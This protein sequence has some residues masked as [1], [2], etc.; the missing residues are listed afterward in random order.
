MLTD[1]NGDFWIT[2]WDGLNRFD[3]V[4]NRFA[5]YK[6]G[7]AIG[8][9]RLWNVTED[10]KGIL[11]MG[12]TAGLNR[13][14]PATGQFTIYG[15]NLADPQSLSDNTATSVLVDHSGRM[16]ITT[17]NGFNE[18]DSSTGKFVTYYK[19]DGLPSSALSCVLEDQVGNLWIGTSN[20]LSKFDPLTRHFQNYST[21]DGIPGGD[22]MGWGTCFKKRDGEMFFAGFSGGVAFYPDRLDSRVNRTPIVLTDFQ[23]SGNSVEVGPRSPLKQSIGYTKNITLTPDEDIFS[24][25]FAALTYFDSS[26]NRYRYKLDGLK[27]D[28]IEVGSDRRTATFIALPAGKYTFRAQFQTK[29]GVWQ[30]P[31]IALPIT[32]LPPW[33]ATPWFQ[34]A[35]LAAFLGL[36]WGLYQLR[37]R[38]LAREFNVGLESRVNERT[39]ISRELHDSLLQVFHALMFRLQSVRDLLPARANEAMEAL[40]IALERGDKAITEARDTVSDLRTTVVGNSGIA[41]ALSALGEELAAQVGNDSVPCLRV[42]LEGKERELNPMLRDEIYCIGR[43]ALRNAFRHAKAQEIEAEITYGDFEFLLR[44]RDD[45]QGIDSDVANQGARTGHWGLPGMRE[46]A[47]SFGG[48]LELWSERGAGTEIELRVPA[49]IAY[50]RSKAPRRFWFLQKKTEEC[51]E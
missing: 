23:L 14:D 33:W 36:L 37:M 18:L 30:D 3:H 26:A 42:L 21:A 29:T 7:P 25:T 35:S 49:P 27:E 34:T 1:H 22:F 11:W 24:L 51:N 9:E 17:Q 15:H 6:P 13:F 39:R 16:W 19:K 20:G 8:R 45:G 28:W 40:D 41:Q 5:V 48:N 32:I 2:T 50:S 44:V 46:R 43:E 31:G 12:G 47:K 10:Q 38:Q 4:H